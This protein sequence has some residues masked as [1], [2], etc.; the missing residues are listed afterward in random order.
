MVFLWKEFWRSSVLASSYVSPVFRL[1]D[2]FYLEPSSQISLSLCRSSLEPRHV[3]SVQRLMLLFLRVSLKGKQHDWLGSRWKTMLHGVQQTSAL[4]SR[5]CCR[6]SE[7]IKTKC[8]QWKEINRGKNSS[9]KKCALWIRK[10]IFL[11]MLSG[12]FNGLYFQGSRQFNRV[13]LVKQ[14]LFKP[15]SPG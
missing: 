6:D 11:R 5:M 3:S 13:W 8:W 15:V 2:S 10:H 9:G 1:T 14:S 7:K 4:F 12:Q